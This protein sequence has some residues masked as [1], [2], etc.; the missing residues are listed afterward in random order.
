MN[1]NNIQNLLSQVAVITK[2]YDDIAEI[3]GENFN[4][5]RI[6][7]ME[8]REV[9]T[10]SAFLAEL[11]NPRG[12]HGQ[13]DV[14]LKLFIEEVF[15]DSNEQNNI[16]SEITYADKFKKS[17]YEKVSFTE[18]FAEYNI[19]LTSEDMENGGQIDI[20][21]NSEKHKIIIENKID[22][23]EQPKQ[24]VR[25]YNYAPNEPLFYL[26]L[27]GKKPE[28]IVGDKIT[29]N[30]GTHFKCISYE[31]H[32]LNW[33]EKCREKAVNHSLLRES[34]TQYI[35]LIKLLTGQTLNKKME[36][37]IFDIC[38]DNPRLIE[39]YLSLPPKKELKIELIRQFGDRLKEQINREKIIINSID[40]RSYCDKPNFI[41]MD[42]KIEGWKENIW[43][44]IMYDYE[45][46]RMTNP[47]I[48]I[49]IHEVSNEERIRISSLY[50]NE[51]KIE[52]D[53]LGIGDDKK[54]SNWVMLYTFNDI[55]INDDLKVWS[56]LFLNFGKRTKEVMLNII[57][58]GKHIELLQSM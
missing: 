6:L 26:T 15:Q 4:I 40:T 14:F 51:I 22:A 24:L 43:L 16:R 3:T 53:K 19:G 42:F 47:T 13:K 1:S 34:L 48:G 45:G 8:R 2:K 44:Q 12:S 29:L 27:D 36:K 20:L 18:S 30:H 54:Y 31:T 46:E 39:A 50:R 35:N 21:I 7:K 57:E 58:V 32:I 56:N 33:L 11:L 25:Y 23:I 17:N 52:F 5:F 49:Y 41:S 28:E 38:H 10:H 9:K 55:D 37:E